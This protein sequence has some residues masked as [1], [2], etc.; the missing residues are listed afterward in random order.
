MY[1]ADEINACLKSSPL[2]RNVHRTQLKVNMRV[3]MLHDPFAEK[4]SKQLLKIGDGNV[5]TDATGYVKLP[6]DFCTIIDSQETLIEKIFPDV[7]TQ[8]INHEWPAERAI[9]AAKK[10]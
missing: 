9:L 6:T 4:F 8:Y 10:C 5:T 2:W 3:Q 7:H 1:Y